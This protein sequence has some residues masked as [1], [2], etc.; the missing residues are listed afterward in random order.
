VNKPDFPAW[1]FSDLSSPCM[2]STFLHHPSSTFKNSQ[3]LPE[4]PYQISVKEKLNKIR[5]ELEASLDNY[6]QN[7]PF[8]FPIQ[9]NT[10]N[11]TVD[12]GA[13]ISLSGLGD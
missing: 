5:K 9:D 3:Q 13:A 10:I 8:L 7:A 1:F 11:P 12:C 6:K 4:C 2:S